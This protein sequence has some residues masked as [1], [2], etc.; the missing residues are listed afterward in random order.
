MAGAV[1]D[2][3]DF[4]EMSLLM[5]ASDLL[6][7]DYSSCAGDFPLLMRPVILFHAP[8]RFERDLYFDVEASPFPIAH[9][10]DQLR[11]LFGQLDRAPENCRAILDF[12]GAHETGR[13]AEAVAQRI[14]QWMDEA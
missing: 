2:K 4:P 10:P 12:F 3:T 8:G 11:A 9:D 6:I 13:S 1:I 14:A 5:Q 7:T